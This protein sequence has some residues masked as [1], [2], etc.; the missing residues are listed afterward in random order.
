VNLRRSLTGDIGSAVA[1]VVAV[2]AII[3]ATA[4][5]V[6]SADPWPAV[7]PS[8]WTA[9]ATAPAVEEPKWTIWPGPD[10]A[11]A[12]ADIASRHDAGHGDVHENCHL[13]INYL[14]NRWGCPAKRQYALYVLQGRCLVLNEPPL[15][16]ADVAA[17]VPAEHRRGLYPTYLIGQRRYWNR[18]PLYL[19]DEWVCY[20]NSIGAPGEGGADGYAAEFTRYA[21]TLLTLA[22]K[23]DGYDA[24]GLR[25]FVRWHADRVRK[26]Q[27]KVKTEGTKSPDAT[28]LSP[29]TP[30]AP[31][32]CPS[33]NCG[34]P[35]GLFYRWRK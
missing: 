16:I 35:G 20:A 7:R 9:I 34:Q 29:A 28:G 4:T 1:I 3:F 19:L 33:G 22:E 8:P 2:L 14:N 11:D 32:T 6:R 23:C 30:A 21:E 18:Q 26:L 12:R 24:S 31:S 15:T 10:T 17:A 13:L 25:V 5:R 27:A